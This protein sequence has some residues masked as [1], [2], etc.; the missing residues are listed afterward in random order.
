MKHMPLS[1]L[2]YEKDL[3]GILVQLVKDM[4][5]KIERQK[6]RAAKESAPRPA[7]PAEQATLDAIKVRAELLVVQLHLVPTHCHLTFAMLPGA[8]ACG[9][10]KCSLLDVRLHFKADVLNFDDSFHVAAS[11]GIHRAVD[12]SGDGS[13]AQ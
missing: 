6:E 4:D 1:R 3:H 10:P 9:H 8:A 13:V 5:R 12:G 11:S 7:T 2:A